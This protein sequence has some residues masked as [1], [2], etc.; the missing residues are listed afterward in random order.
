MSGVTI[1]SRSLAAR[2]PGNQ[3][4]GPHPAPRWK[5]TVLTSA[6]PAVGHGEAE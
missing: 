1:T 2:A 5:G 3:A 4:L 6:L